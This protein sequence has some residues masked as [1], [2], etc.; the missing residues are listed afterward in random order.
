MTQPDSPIYTCAPDIP[1]IRE[2]LLFEKIA[3]TTYSDNVSS[4][5]SQITITQLSLL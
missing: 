3:A 5:S 1:I 4:N 2:V